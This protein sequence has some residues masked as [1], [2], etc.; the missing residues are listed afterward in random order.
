MGLGPQPTALDGGMQ[1]KICSVIRLEMPRL[2]TEA[3]HKPI[4]SIGVF[5]CLIIG[6]SREKFIAGEREGT[7]K[8]QDS[9]LNTEGKGSFPKGAFHSSLKTQFTRFI[10]H[11]FPSLASQSQCF[12]T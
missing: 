10:K 5:S 3:A 12:H 2:E 11:S 1:A 6:A 9:L 8:Q 4:S 7:D